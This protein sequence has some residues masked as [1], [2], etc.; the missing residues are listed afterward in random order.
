MFSKGVVE[1]RLRGVFEEFLRE[2][3]VIYG[4]GYKTLE[5]ILTYLVCA[6]SVDGL[7]EWVKGWSFEEYWAGDFTRVGCSVPEVTDVG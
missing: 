3:G 7:C 6:C 2:V 5:A 4:S 1:F